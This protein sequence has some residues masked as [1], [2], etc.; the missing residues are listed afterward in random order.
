LTQPDKALSLP[1]LHAAAPMGVDNDSVAAG[2]PLPQQGTPV[3][4]WV[5]CRGRRSAALAYPEPQ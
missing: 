2:I 4:F 1:G 5:D 3:Y